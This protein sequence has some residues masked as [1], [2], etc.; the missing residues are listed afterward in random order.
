MLDDATLWLEEPL[1]RTK[2]ESFAKYVG[3]EARLFTQ[4]GVRIKCAHSDRGGEFLGNDFTAHLERQGTTRKLTVHDTPEHNGDAERSHLTLGNMRRCMLIASGLPKWLWGEAHKHAV[5]LWNRTPHA[6]IGFSTPYEARFGKKPDLSGLKPF[7]AVC[8]VRKEKSDKLGARADEGRW[9]GFDDTSNGIRVYST[10]KNSVSVERNIVVSSREISPL[11]GE[12]YSIEM[13][14]I[15]SID[16]ERNLITH[17][18]VAQPIEDVNP[19]EEIQEPVPEGVVTGK[20]KRKPSSKVRAIMDGKAITGDELDEAHFTIEMNLA[21]AAS[22]ASA[23]D[24]RTVGEAM[25]RPDA[26][27][28]TGAMNDEIGRLAKHKTWI[29]VTPTS[30]MNVIDSKWVFRHKKDARGN[31]IGHRAR[32]VARGFT[33]IEGV[34]YTSDDTYAPVAKMSSARTCLAI[35]AQRDYEIH[36][37]DVKSAYLYGRMEEGENIYM[38]PPRGTQLAGIKPGQ[39]LK[40]QACI[41]GLKQAGRRWAKKFRSVMTD[42]GLTRSE[43]DHGVF[44]RYLPND[45]FVV[46]FI[47]VDDMTMIAP[48]MKHMDALKRKI[49]DHVEVVDSGEVNWML[50]IEIKRDRRKR[51]ISLGQE[52]YVTQILSRY[53]FEDLR[54]LS[55]PLNS[56]LVLSK[57]Q[58][59]TSVEE[60][61]M[62]RDKPYRETLGALMYAS[63]ATRPDITYAVS[64]LSRFSE[65]PGMAH[66]NAVK[67][68]YA[69]LKGTKGWW[70]TLGGDENSPAVGYSDADGMSN[71]DRH[72][73]SGYAFLIGGAVSWSSKRQEIVS[74][75]TTEAEYVALTHAFKEAIWLRNFIIEVFRAPPL[76]MN[77]KS[78]S[79]GAIALAKDDKF[80]A[81]TKHIDI[82]FHFVRYNI[83]DKKIILTYC[84][85]D[86]MT[87][88]IF[89]KALDNMKAKHFAASLGLSQA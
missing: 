74:V 75:S 13:P 36:Q 33:Q 72:A 59:P 30:D 44:Y 71:P 80:H 88:D 40:L 66:W 89:T 79:M 35:A 16:N 62:M 24:P 69:Y 60:I 9:L 46:L 52:S 47:H 4:F 5:W 45:E 27:Q 86:D 78:D 57:D 65:K 3:Y 55:T 38:R 15:D 23:M 56:A 68:V 61:A 37:M 18:P 42:V 63:V 29:Y 14:A 51:T 22:D 58:S 8:Y 48:S 84:P 76:P 87:A 19:A 31:I 50:G 64:L 17:D 34:D 73:I 81:R 77:V 10:S 54:I 85:T 70:L 26:H 7:G 49:K 83:E 6:A 32:L 21:D 67:R 28:W 12:D 20:R 82:R 41:Y 25:K 1:L 11:E 39:V 53:G 43:L 2:G